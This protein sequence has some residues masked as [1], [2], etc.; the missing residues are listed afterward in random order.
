[1]SSM[2]QNFIKNTALHIPY[3]YA[4]YL[5]KVPNLGGSNYGMKVFE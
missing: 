1:M 4:I 5:P 2:T 3:L